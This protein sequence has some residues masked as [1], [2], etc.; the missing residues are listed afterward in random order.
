MEC[1]FIQKKQWVDREK[2]QKRRSSGQR[3]EYLDVGETSRSGLSFHCTKSVV[4]D[5]QKENICDRGSEANGC[6]SEE[7]HLCSQWRSFYKAGT[8]YT[9]F[10]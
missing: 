5:F 6:A 8:L 1:T 10:A 3:W 9:E 7:A 4:L 2:V